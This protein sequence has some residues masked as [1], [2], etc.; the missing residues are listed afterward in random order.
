MGISCSAFVFP[1]KQNTHVCFGKEGA[2]LFDWVANCLTSFDRVADARYHVKQSVW[3]GDS[4]FIKAV[5]DTLQALMQKNKFGNKLTAQM[6]LMQLSVIAH[7]C[8]AAL[9]GNALPM[10]RIYDEV[11][12][13]RALACVP[14][15]ACA[16]HTLPCLAVGEGAPGAVRERH[17]HLLAGQQPP[18]ALA[19]L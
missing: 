2:P 7:V 13:A 14:S 1:S 16:A 6:W 9:P 4:L 18:Q 11:P 19:V 5:G 17:L 12:A 15:P 10:D 8:G 3:R